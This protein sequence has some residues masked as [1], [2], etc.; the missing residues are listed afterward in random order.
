MANQLIRLADANDISDILSIYSPY[1]TDTSITFENT[2]PSF[3]VFEQRMLSIMQDYPVLV[4]TNDEKVTGFSYASKLKERAAYQWCAELSVYL[5]IDFHNRG[6]GSILYCA[7][8]EILKLQQIKNVYGVVTL[9]NIASERLHA[10]LD[11][12]EL[13]T[14]QN[15]GYKLGKWHDVKWFEKFISPHE[16][17]PHSLIPVREI[18][19]HLIEQLLGDLSL[20][21]CK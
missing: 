5:D 18:N 11:F 19:K 12:H 13:C 9:P 4:F 2:I 3:P 10:S 17:P 20:I 21:S 7:L 14:F 15:S 16:S 6:I 8:I 1:I